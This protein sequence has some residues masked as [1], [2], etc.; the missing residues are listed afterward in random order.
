M[1][2][3]MPKMKQDQAARLRLGVVRVKSHL[4]CG[5]GRGEGRTLPP[6]IF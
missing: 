1:K 6:P 5:W 3:T 2:K 4:R